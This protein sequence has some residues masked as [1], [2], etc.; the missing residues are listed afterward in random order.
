MDEMMIDAPFVPKIPALLEF[1]NVRN[2]GLNLL[3]KAGLRKACHQLTELAKQG[4]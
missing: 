4:A 1:L 2:Y 3:D